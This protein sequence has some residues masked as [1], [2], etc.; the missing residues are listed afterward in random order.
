MYHVPL[1][2]QYIYGHGDGGENEDEEEGREW[3]LPGLFYADH[4]VLYGKLEKDLRAMVGCFAEVC[5]RRGL[6]VSAPR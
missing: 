5:R 6:K 1:A 3:S 4:L 2:L